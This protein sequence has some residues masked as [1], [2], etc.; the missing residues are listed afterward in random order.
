MRDTRTAI[1]SA[2]AAYEGFGAELDGKIARD[3]IAKLTAARAASAKA[4]ADL[5]HATRASSADARAALDAVEADG[6]E[7]DRE[8][9]RAIDA[10]RW[11]DLPDLAMFTRAR[12][13]TEAL[14]KLPGKKPSAWQM[15]TA[16]DQGRDASIAESRLWVCFEP[17]EAHALLD[18]RWRRHNEGQ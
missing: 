16:L 4:Q 17:S 7:L 18:L 1:A 10:M 14:A 8:I 9:R 13:T 5:H 12:Q 2:L 6:R 3:L 15:H 11:V